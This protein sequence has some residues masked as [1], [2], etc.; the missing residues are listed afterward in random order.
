MS[1]KFG[2]FRFLSIVNLLIAGFFVLMMLL[3]LLF[4]VAL[5]P[6]LIF[7]LLTGAVVIHS[8]LSISLQQSLRDSSR[9]LKTNTPGGIRIMGFMAIFYAVLLI[10]N[11]FVGLSHMDEMLTEVLKQMPKSQPVPTIKDLRGMMTGL[12]IFLLIH[13]LGVLVNCALSFTFLKYWQINTG[14]TKDSDSE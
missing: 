5:S 4:M 13:A 7:M 2:L 6:V 9:P 3:A 8:V 14:R 10:S 11:G 12:I 1:S